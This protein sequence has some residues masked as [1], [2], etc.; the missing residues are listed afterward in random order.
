MASNSHPFSYTL[1]SSLCLSMQP[2]SMPRPYPRLS[3][4]SLSFLSLV[5]SLSLFLFLLVSWS[6]CFPPLPLIPLSIFVCHCSQPFINLL[7][8]PLTSVLKHILLFYIF[9]LSRSLSLPLSLS[10]SLCLFICLR[11]AMKS[12]LP[13]FTLENGMTCVLTSE[14]CM[15]HWPSACVAASVDGGVPEHAY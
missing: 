7:S 8:S 6:L 11:M 3:S 5:I 14:C 2:W 12:A 15:E 4:L 9:S 1:S 10:L 13:P